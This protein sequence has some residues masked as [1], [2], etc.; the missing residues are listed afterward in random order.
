MSSVSTYEA[1]NHYYQTDYARQ[2]EG[3]SECSANI[4]NIG[5]TLGNDCPYRCSH[6]YSM[7][8]RRKG[9]DFSEWMVERIVGELKGNGVETVNLGG[10]EPIFTNGLDV[11]KSLL[12]QI[13][14][15]L[16]DVGILVGLT[17]SGITLR[18]LAEYYPE[19]VT[20]LNDCDISLDSPDPEE[21]NANRGAAIFSEAM[22]SLEICNRYG[23]E[24]SII[25]CGMSWNF[26]PS[27]LQKLVTIARDQDA[28]IRINPIKT[29]EARHMA[30]ELSPAQYYSGFEYLMSVCDAV[31]LGEPPLATACRSRSANG[32]PCGRTSFRI[33][34]ITPDGR[35]PVSPCVYLHDFKSGDLLVDDLRDIVH[36]APFRDFRARNLHPELVNG[37]AGCSLIDTCRGGCV[38]RSYLWAVHGGHE[39]TLRARDPYCPRDHADGYRFPEVPTIDTGD[40]RLVHQDYLCTWIGKPRSA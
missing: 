11:R 23:I 18:K 33:H 36:S 24:R 4:K 20:L 17:T 16:H 19:S 28:N 25:M 5:W 40:K 3:V 26:S 29:V 14:R 6:C 13:I 9:A 12:P 10:N 7:S 21:H 34:S 8:A 39:G 31:D 32:C 2:F 30:M 35:I 22:A 15:R 38:A 1:E 27:K 37:C